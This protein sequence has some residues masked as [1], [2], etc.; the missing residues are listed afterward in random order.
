ML[1]TFAV[2][3]FTATFAAM[4]AITHPPAMIVAGFV[5]VVLGSYVLLPLIFMYCVRRH[6][7]HQVRRP[8]TVPEPNSEQPY[9][10]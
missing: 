7:P 9:S 3:A 6:Y 2:F 1:L 5:S 8:D 10:F 4:N